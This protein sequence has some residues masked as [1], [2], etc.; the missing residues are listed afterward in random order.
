MK[1]KMAGSED[2]EPITEPFKM[3]KRIKDAYKQR[4]WV[5]AARARKRENLKKLKKMNVASGKQK[6]F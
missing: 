2:P 3:K 6:Q 4:D 5:L 1:D